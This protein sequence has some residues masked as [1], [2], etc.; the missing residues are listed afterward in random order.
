MIFKVG[1]FECLGAVN[2]EHRNFGVDLVNFSRLG[3]VVV[4]ALC[5]VFVE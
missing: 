4:D 1:L 5:V 3:D 2:V